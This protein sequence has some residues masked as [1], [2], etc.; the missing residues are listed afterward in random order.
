MRLLA[1]LA[2]LLTLTLAWLVSGCSDAPRPPGDG[3][4][5]ED[6]ATGVRLSSAT[7]VVDVARAP[8]R[9]ELRAAGGGD[10]IA[11]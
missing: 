7:T 8:Y 1:P 3:I 5:V 2:P 10:A 11:G 6:T 9:L 4:R